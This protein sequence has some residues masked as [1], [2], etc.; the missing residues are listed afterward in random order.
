MKD[1]QKKFKGMDLDGYKTTLILLSILLA[2]MSLVVFMPLRNSGHNDT[3][4]FASFS[5]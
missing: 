5:K 2:V 4:S 3:T 1:T